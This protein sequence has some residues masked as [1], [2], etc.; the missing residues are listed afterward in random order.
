VGENGQELTRC[1]RTIKDGSWTV[2][3]GERVRTKLEGEWGGEDDGESV[4]ELLSEDML[5]WVVA[6]EKQLADGSN[7]RGIS[8]TRV[9]VELRSLLSLWDIR[10]PFIPSL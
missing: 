2:G 8:Q 10:T 6:M 9:V 7:G 4:G 5:A 3:V 1:G